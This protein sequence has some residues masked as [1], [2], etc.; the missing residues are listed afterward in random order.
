MRI[1]WKHV[2]LLVLAAVASASHDESQGLRFVEDRGVN[3]TACLDHHRPCASIQYALSQAEPG[4]TVRV[5][6]GIY[7][8]ADLDPEQFLF[9]GKRA[10]GGYSDATEYEVQDARAN[11][12]ILLGVEPRYRLAMAKQGFT[13]A[14]DRASAESG[15]FDDSTPPALQSKGAAP[16]TCQSGMAGQFPCRNVDFLAQ[17]TLAEFSTRPSS[18]A[19]VWGL[20]DLNDN[21][22][23][24]V[25]GLRN[26]T[27]VVDVTDPANPREVTTIPGNSSSWREVKLYQVRDPVANRYRAYAYITTEASGSGL[28]IIDLS[29]LPNTASLATT[30]TDTGTQHTAYIS[31]INYGS[32]AALPGAQAFLY[33]AG[34]NVAGGAWRAYSLA[35]PAQPQ[36]VGNAT[37]GSGYMHD[38]TSLLLTD[39]R[40]AQ[41]EPG[42]NPCEVL[43]DFNETTVDL[44]DVTN[45][46][47]PV[48]LSTTTY[49]GVEYTHSGWPTSDQRFIMIHDEL[50]EIRRGFNTQ[51]YT[52]NIDNL[53]LP[54]VVTSFRGPETTTDHNGYIKGNRYYVSHYRRGLVVFDATNPQ[55][56]VELGSFDTFLNPVSNAAGTDGA[57]GVYPF[58]P[59]GT[60]LI[61]DISNGLF[62]VREQAANPAGRLAFSGTGA[63]V[64]ENAGSVT[65]QVERSAGSTGAVSVNYS[66]SNGS[67]LAGTDYTAVSGTLQWATGETGARSVVIQVSNNTSVTGNRNFQ[68]LLSNVAGGAALDGANSYAITI[69]EDD[70]APP[71]APPASSGGGGGQI[72]WWLLALLTALATRLPAPRPE[73]RVR[74]TGDATRARTAN[75]SALIWI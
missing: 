16:A 68:L 41:C 37:P 29:G 32:N 75:F 71:V 67:A 60:I 7:S 39:A 2:P 51:I 34:S 27:A 61:S 58:L 26:G 45:K 12:T 59:S 57:W 56:L 40:T 17:V 46:S 30:L 35:N 10:A 1:N 6:A 48:R 64:L 66:S 65:V 20:V 14:A 49:P 3:N 31:N 24:A 33:L 21:R 15:I 70:V 53:R 73:S 74:S 52:L 55:Q 25:V 54:S 42:H 62:L 44:W 43:V 4:H 22:E 5:A 23:Y 8:V 9:G 63:A 38:S 19:N 18:A 28:Q 11:R 47:T 72:E 50:E 69:Q 36:L 13:W